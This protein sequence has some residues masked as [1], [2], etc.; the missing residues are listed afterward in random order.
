MCCISIPLVFEAS[1]P[2]MSRAYA[3]TDGDRGIFDDVKKLLG[4]AKE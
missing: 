3:L 1:T 2:M 4:I